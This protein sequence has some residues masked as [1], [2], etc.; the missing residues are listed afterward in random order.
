MSEREAT[1]LSTPTSP[2]SPTTP[3]TPTV[4]VLSVRR[5]QVQ[6][7]VLSIGLTLV[8]LAALLVLPLS[9][10]DV[11][12]VIDPFGP[13]APVVYVVVG[14]VLGC[15]FVP[16]PL[17][18]AASGA[19]FGTWLGVVVSICSATLGAVIATVVARR[20][21]QVPVDTLAG[22]RSSALIALARRR[23]LLVVVLQRWL[24]GVPDA[25][26]SYAFGALGLGLPAVALGTAFG[27]APRAFAYTALGDAA[28]TGNGSLA[29]VALAVGG[30]ISVVGVVA[31][32]V[33]VRRGRARP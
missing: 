10:D 2:T 23:G 21:G 31:G 9:R 8:G 26:F 27:A 1:P 5:A 3:T 11:A 32:V 7:A 12:R 15:L 25:P 24:P 29:V 28:V 16:G 19:L 17:L 6:L 18:A 13:F 4:P 20:A 30:A 22:E 14:A 33:V